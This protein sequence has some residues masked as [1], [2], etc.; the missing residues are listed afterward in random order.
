M[1]YKYILV[2]EDGNLYGTNDEATADYA[3]ERGNCLGID[4]ELG[5]NLFT[6]KTI[7]ECPAPEPQEEDGLDDD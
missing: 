2:D 6:G 3:G 5:T 7:P 4:C 1:K